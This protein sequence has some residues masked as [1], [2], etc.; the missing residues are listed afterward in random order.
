VGLANHDRARL[1]Q[2]PNHLAVGRDRAWKAIGAVG[3]QLAGKVMVVLEGDRHPQQRPLLAPLQPCLGLLG[4]E[5]G[6]LG[7]HD[8]ERVQLRVESL[9][10]IE[11]EPHE[12]GRRDLA[13]AYHLSLLRRARKGDLLAHG[14]EGY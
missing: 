9:D 8:P 12:L 1:A 2:P 7:E 11:A 6:S 14:G 10:P 13:R 4:L 3:G 5:Q